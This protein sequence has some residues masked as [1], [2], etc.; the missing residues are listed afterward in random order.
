[1]K[2][3]AIVQVINIIGTPTRNHSS[4]DILCPPLSLIDMAITFA[5]EPIGVALPPKPQPM[6]KAQYSGTTFTSSLS[7]PNSL[8]TGSIAAQKGILSTMAEANAETQIRTIA[9]ITA[10]LDILPSGPK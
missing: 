1:M 8:M 3:V 10:S 9:S 4:V 7:F 2:T 5:L 6:A